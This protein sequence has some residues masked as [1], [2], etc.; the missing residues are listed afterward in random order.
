[1]DDFSDTESESSASAAG[2]DAADFMQMAAELGRIEE[3]PA[4]FLDLRNA[5]ET[6][7]S[8]DICAVETVS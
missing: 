3:T 2:W 7:S 5:F 8:L 6:L 4:N 1:M